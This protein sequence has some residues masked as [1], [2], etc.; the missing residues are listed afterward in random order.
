MLKG[1][2]F[3]EQQIVADNRGEFISWQF[4]FFNTVESYTTFNLAKTFRGLHVVMNGQ[5]KIVS[6]L[7][8]EVE[9]YIVD[10]NEGSDSYGACMV[11]VL[12]K[13]QSVYVPAGC[14][15]GYKSAKPSVIH[16]LMNRPFDASLYLTYSP[17]CA[18]LN[19]PDDWHISEKD[20]NG[21]LLK[22]A[23]CIY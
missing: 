10:V 3:F 20:R 21:L 16:Y 17:K 4:P 15:H 7:E 19:I 1:V 23:A 2:R 11:F 5:A 14:A 9:D 12:G 6:C 18:G 8:G 22:E 13:G